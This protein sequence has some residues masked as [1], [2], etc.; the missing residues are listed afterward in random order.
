MCFSVFELDSGSH[1]DENK[2]VK[3]SVVKK[4]LIIGLAPSVQENYANLQKLWIV[5]G[6]AQPSKQFCHRR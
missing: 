4:L 3:N 6:Y 5:L 1:T 2:I